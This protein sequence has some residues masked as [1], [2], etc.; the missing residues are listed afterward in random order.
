MK[1]ENLCFSYGKKSVFS[2]LNIGTESK[3]ICL[4]GKSGCGKTTLLH[5]IAGLLRQDS[6]SITGIKRPCSV[7]FQE[8]RLLP[9]LNA[10]ENVALV[11]DNKDDKK[12]SALLRDLGLEPD[13]ELSKMS[14]GMKRRVA[15]ARALAFKSETLLLDE[16]FKGLD[17]N[18]MRSCAQ[19]IKK[20]GKLTIV[21]THSVKE[22]EALDATIIR[23]DDPDKI[24]I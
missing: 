23:I 3:T 15:L 17:E 18:L 14:G 4:M 5:L 12:T 20:E 11:L 16:P 6:G 19:L 8:D 10:K 7:M 9:W 24:G 13:M 1:I 21:S 22:A 2:N